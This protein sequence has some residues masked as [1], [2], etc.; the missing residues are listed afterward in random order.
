MVAEDA[1][2]HRNKG[3]MTTPPGHLLD[4][5]A[6]RYAN[7]ISSNISKRNSGAKNFPKAT[8]WWG[9]SGSHRY[10]TLP[11]SSSGSPLGAGRFSTLTIPTHPRQRLP[12]LLWQSQQDGQ[13]LFRHPRRGQLLIQYFAKAGFR[14]R[15]RDNA[16]LIAAHHDKG[17][18]ALHKLCA[19]G[20][21]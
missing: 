6:Q 21:I 8:L 15:A 12:L 3:V 17:R 20:C 5:S 10:H 1:Y 16:S 2:T 13:S 4:A 19:F 18:R 14:Q 9:L 11:A 7:V